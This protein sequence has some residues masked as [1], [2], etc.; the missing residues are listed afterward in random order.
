MEEGGFL[1]EP[2][3]GAGPGLSLAAAGP[4]PPWLPPT[5]S[6]APLLHQGNALQGMAR[7]RCLKLP[8]LSLHH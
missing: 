7:Q 6:P 1:A 3:A 4:Q 5:A 8:G 2:R